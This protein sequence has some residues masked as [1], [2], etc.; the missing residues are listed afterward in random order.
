MRINIRRI[1]LKSL[2]QKDSD[3][4]N[5]VLEKTEGA[6]VFHTI[7]WNRL[8]IERFALEHV[9]LI[10]SASQEPVGMYLIYKFDNESSIS[11]VVHLQSA[12]GGPIAIN[13]DKEVIY[14]LLQE[15]ER[16]WPFSFFEVWTPP[17][18]DLLPFLNRG[19]KMQEMSTPIM[20]LSDTE[21]KRW[22]R[23]SKSKRDKIRKALKQGAYV[24]EA[25]LEDLAN[26]HIMVGATLANGGKKPLPLDFYRTALDCLR[27]FG[28]AKFF[29][30]KINHEVIS[31]CVVLYF[32]DTV[33]GWDIGWKREFAGLSPNDLLVWEVSQR[34][35]REGYKFFDLLRIEPDRLPG[36]AKW[37]E[38]FGGEIV[39]CYYFRKGTFWLRLI[40]PFKQILT[41]PRKVITKLRARVRIGNGQ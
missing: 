10:A 16:I 33:Y 37:K 25:K 27:P 11:P 17:Q 40:L 30:V 3:D 6:S 13:D 28:L 35:S 9:A 23:L 34:A 18:V 12:Y 5:Y 41:D 26:Y 4:I 2:S 20:K 8:L 7:Q 1:N 15:S 21:E 19:Y 32:K 31:G 22:S 38:G 24:M 29:I 36:I 14:K 39:K